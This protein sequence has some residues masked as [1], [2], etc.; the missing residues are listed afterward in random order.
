MSASTKTWVN[1]QAPSCEDDD[2]NGFKLENNNL[3]EGS[4][5]SLD[6]GDNQQTHKAVATYA[7]VGEYMLGAGVADAYTANAPSP[8]IN[9]EARETGMVIRFQAAADNTGACT[10]NAFGTGVD[11]IKLADGTTDPA[12]G[13]IVG[14]EDV[15]V[16]D[17]STYFELFNPKVS[18][19]SVAVDKSLWPTVSNGA[20]A[21]HD[22]DF[23]SGKISDSNGTLLINVSAL[24]K[25]LDANW[26][27]GDNAGGLFTG[28]IAADTTY[29]CF[30]IVKDSDGSVD[31]GFDIDISASN[32]PSGYTAH[33]RIA[34]I[35]TDSSANIVGFTQSADYFEIKAFQRD[36]NDSTGGTTGTVAAV[37]V[38]TGLTS[39][40]ANLLLELVGNSSVQ[41]WVQSVDADNIAPSTTNR[42]LV[43]ASD[44]SLSATERV[45]P[46][47]SSGQVRYR[48]SA[49][50]TAGALN[51][52]TL[53]WFDGREE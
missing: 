26:A 52:F 50:P 9:P 48:S 25:Q 7:L 6:T 30:A 22:I 16:I 34:S 11:D 23:S 40:R 42:N 32:I 53:G 28:T 47:N 17:R 49:S 33:R 13:D 37:A 51:I 29:H 10:L 45:V 31:A 20:D 15:T 5:Q 2:L 36:V 24:T 39:I 38:P 41:C 1:N 43:I 18:N 19:V 14:G 4:G 46:V 21:D 3:I 35:F 12:A 8:R 44:D 27:A